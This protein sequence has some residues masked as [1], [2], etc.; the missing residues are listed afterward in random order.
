MF[1]P[2]E[3]SLL[4]R[5]FQRSAARTETEGDRELRAMRIIALYRAGVT[6]EHRLVEMIVDTPPGR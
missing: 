2:D 3:L 1:D 5:V 4:N 6:E